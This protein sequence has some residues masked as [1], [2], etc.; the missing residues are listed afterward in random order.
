MKWLDVNKQFG[1]FSFQR[2]G[3]GYQDN[4]LLFALDASVALGPVAFSMQALTVGSPLTEFDPTFSLKG[5]ALSFEAPPIAIGGAFLKETETVGGKEIDAYYGE[6][7]VKAATFSL[8][9]LGGWA[10]EADPAFFFIYLSIDVPLGGPPFLFVTGLAGGFG[11]NSQ[12]VLPTIDEVAS[13]PL[14]P[15][16]APAEQGSPADTI[17]AVLPALRR[18]FQPLAGQYWVA[19]GISFT[20][21]EMIEAHAV[22]SVAFGV[23]LQIGVVGTC[24]MTFP[25][26][27]P[28]PVAYVEIDVVASFTP[29]T[30]LLAVDGKLSPAS[31]LFGGFVKLTGGF[32]FYAWFSGES[33]GDFVVSLGG[34]HPAFV[35]PANYPVVPRL[36]AG[37]LARPG[38]GRRAGVLR[39]D[40]GHVHGRPAAVGHVRGGA[41]QGVVRRRAWT[42]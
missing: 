1:I 18:T 8:K 37:V 35:R 26:G 40:P 6:L 21:F 24:A 12:L 10:P 11:I 4:V 31:Y 5:L 32:A 33:Q 28:D 39:P 41:G 3:A 42:S 16:N 19:A 9:A 22:V 29:A 34:Y 25:T 7:I 23:N 15:G 27:A 14:L 30:G 20:S 36:G 13:Y 17:K 2:V 38:Q